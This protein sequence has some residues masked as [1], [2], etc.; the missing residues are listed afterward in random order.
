[1][2]GVN[3]TIFTEST[4]QADEFIDMVTGKA[5]WILDRLQFFAHDGHDLGTHGHTGNSDNIN[6]PEKKVFLFLEGKRCLSWEFGT[7]AFC[8][9]RLNYIY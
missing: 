3:S 2:H 7:D 4:L 8:D 1:M 6:D 9:V 5:G